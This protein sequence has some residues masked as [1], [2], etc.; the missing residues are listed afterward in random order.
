MTDG[1]LTEFSLPYRGTGK[2]TVRVYVPSHEEGETFPVI[3]MTDGQSIFYDDTAAYGCWH[4]PAAV[5]EERRISGMAAIIVGI[6]NDESP[7]QRAGELTPTSIGEIHFHPA[8][9]EEIRKQIIPSGEAFD[10]FVINTVMPEIEARFPVKTGRNSTAFCGSSSGG[11]QAFFTAM[12]HPDK[13]C[14]G[15]VFSPVF[16]MYTLEDINSWLWKTV[17]ENMPY[18][19][20]YTGAGDGLEKSICQG[21]EPVYDMM[22]EC[23]PMDKLNEVVMLEQPHNESAW[24]P[25]FRDFLH[26][27]L[28]RREEF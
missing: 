12:T 18:L 4:T 2:K 3:Y 27:F 13:F 5:E 11:L 7:A 6:H 10:D 14:A 17:G 15:G 21:L 28:T 16:E 1:R 20:F 23:Y 8:M 25:I 19:Y 22:L 9:P 24:E 26:T